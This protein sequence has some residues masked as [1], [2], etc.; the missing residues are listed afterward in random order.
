MSAPNME[1]LLNVDVFSS[2]YRWE[3]HVSM[4]KSLNYL[5]LQL[6]QR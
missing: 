5:W 6:L 4:Y 2:L 3:V 1:G